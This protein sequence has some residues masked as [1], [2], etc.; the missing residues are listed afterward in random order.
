MKEPTSDTMS[1]SPL[2]IG[3][4][5]LDSVR[6]PWQHRHAYV[7]VLLPMILLQLALGGAWRL[8]APAKSYWALAIFTGVSFL[9]T[10]KLVVL[11]HRIVILGNLNNAEH[12]PTHWRQRDFEFFAWML[13]VFLLFIGPYEFQKI[14]HYTEPGRADL[15]PIATLLFSLVTLYVVNRCSLLLSAVATDRKITLVQAWQLG[16]RNA[17]RF[18]LAFWI[19]PGS[20]AVV[21]IM[22]TLAFISNPIVKTV[23]AS[24]V[25]TLFFTFQGTSQALA[26]KKLS[27]HVLGQ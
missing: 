4:F 27:S 25:N 18:G 16:A 5:I 7:R 21:L 23:I 26:Y 13:F 15:S 22:A 20:V 14:L 12:L 11:V 1:S 17:L 24:L 8:T 9:V 3:Q 10:A 6:Y 2:M 19:V